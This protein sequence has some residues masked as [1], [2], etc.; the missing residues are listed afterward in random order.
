MTEAPAIITEKAP[1]KAVVRSRRGIWTII[2][3]LVIAGL[4]GGAYYLWGDVIRAYF[5]KNQPTPGEVS[6]AKANGLIS[7]NTTRAVRKT[8]IRQVEQAGSILPLA[9]AEMFAKVS[10]YLKFIARDVTPGRVAQNILREGINILQ[11]PGSSPAVLVTQGLGLNFHSWRIAP[12]KDIGSLVREGEAVMILDEPE[13]RSDV[14]QKQAVLQQRAAELAQA[15]AMIAT[16]D[17]GLDA[18]VAKEKSA[19]ADL[20]RAESECATR[21]GEYQRYQSLL[22]DKAVQQDQVDEK[23]NY[24][25]AAKA[26]C[27]AAQA[28]MD[29]EKAEYSVASSKLTAARADLLVKDALVTVAR[30][31]LQRAET[32]AQYAIIRAP[33]DG[34]ITERTVD[35]G[36]FIQNASTGQSK[37][38]ITITALEQVRM[39]MQVPEKEVPWTHIGAEAIIHFDAKEHWQ[40]TGHVSRIARVLDQQ[41][42]TMRI[43]IDLDNREGKLMPGMYGHVTLVL[44]KLDNAM[45]IPATAVFSRRGENYIVLAAQGQ[46]HRVPVRI[47]FDNGEELEVVKLVEG[48]EIPLNGAEDLIISNKGEIA[49]GQKIKATPLAKK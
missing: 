6:N 30:E 33:F 5:K 8:L 11:S 9:Q 45:A 24:Y 38:L 40:S 3:L 43:E 12:Q 10:G 19:H 32:L 27:E 44:Q 28:K 34:V 23:K 49:D 48:Q 29:A 22:A 15:K 46:A 35:E 16:Y 4:G 1:T 41:S 31:D 42:R 14:A 7:V 2:F 13:L 17:A 20:G 37:P 47:R 26:A 25:L 21:Q 18:A 39:I 36:D